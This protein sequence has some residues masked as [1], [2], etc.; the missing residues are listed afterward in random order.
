MS[1]RR[2]AVLRGGPSE[3]YSVS[4]KTG[5]KVLNALQTLGHPYKDITISKK[6]EWLENGFVK[7][8]E[9]A[10]EAVDIVFIAL[11]GTYGEDGQVQRILE[12]KKVPF[13]GSRSLSSAIAFNKELTKHSLKNKGILMPRHRRLD[14]SDLLNL[15]E[16]INHIFSEVGNELFVKPLA[17][18]SSFGARYVPSKEILRTAII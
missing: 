8:P 3:E 18:G 4:M 6:G 17:N 16:E 9:M 13:T 1:Y 14:R 2:V 10:L 5:A 15:D 12:R 7:Q 11:H